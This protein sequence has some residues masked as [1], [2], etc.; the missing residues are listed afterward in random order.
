MIPISLN[1]G[2]NKNIINFSPHNFKKIFRW[3]NILPVQLVQLVILIVTQG[4]FLA[5]SVIVALK[6]ERRRKLEEK[7]EEEEEE[8]RLR[9]EVFLNHLLNESF[10]FV[11]K[12]K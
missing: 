3:W 10:R 2:I 5:H 6:E 9:E 1:S 11:E 12:E 4:P 7:M 8:K